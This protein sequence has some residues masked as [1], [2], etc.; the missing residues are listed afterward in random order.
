[1]DEDMYNGHEHAALLGHTNKVLFARW[2]PAANFTLASSGADRQIKIWD[3]EQ[4][5]EI[6]S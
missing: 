3:V 4:G 1:L 5:Q 6:M 2:N